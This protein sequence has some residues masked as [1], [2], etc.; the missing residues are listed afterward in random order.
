LPPPSSI[1]YIQY[2]H[3]RDSLVARSARVPHNHRTVDRVTRILELVASHP[4]L[5]ASQLA[6][7]L[8]APK[9]SVHGFIDGLL[10][11]GWLH[12]QDRRFFVGP[13]VYGFTLARGQIRAGLVTQADL[14]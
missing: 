3:M 6:R 1:Q 7:A 9:S 5:T 2:A 11:N 13:V 12:E 14:A 8:D 10:A 4:A